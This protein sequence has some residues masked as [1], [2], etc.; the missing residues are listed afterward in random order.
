[1]PRSILT[2]TVHRPS[3][4]DRLAVA[5]YNVTLFEGIAYQVLVLGLYT[6]FSFTKPGVQAEWLSLQLSGTA[7]YLRVASG[8]MGPTRHYGPHPSGL[9]LRL[10]LRTL[11]G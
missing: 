7:V 4:S 9:S 5:H 3:R 10:C 6:D 11:Q 8:S 1:M 2:P